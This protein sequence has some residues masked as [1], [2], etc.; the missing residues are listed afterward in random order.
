[1]ESEYCQS[2]T[3]GTLRSSDTIFV[4]ERKRVNDW[5]TK[6]MKSNKTL[7]DLKLR[8]DFMS[9]LSMNVHSG[10]LKAPF[11]QD[12]VRGPL[13][14]VAKDLVISAFRYYLPKFTD[15][16]LTHAKFAVHYALE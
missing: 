10:E 14:L 11:D 1:M 6:I 9:Y 16:N 2:Q 12:P 4:A 5:I 13:K 3:I 8:N 15:P 7:S